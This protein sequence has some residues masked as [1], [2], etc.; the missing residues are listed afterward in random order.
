MPFRAS[1]IVT[2]FLTLAL[3][4]PLSIGWLPTPV[5]AQQ[6][7]TSETPVT[8]RWLVRLSAP[9]LAQ[10]PNLQPGRAMLAVDATSTSGPRFTSNQA[11]QYRQT[12]QQQQMALFASIQQVLPAAQLQRSYQTV[13]NGISVALPGADAQAIQRIDALPNVIGVYPDHQYEPH[14]YGSIPLINAETLWNNP[15]IGGVANAG[16]GMKIAVIDSGIMVDNPFLN[17]E[18]YAYP[19]GYPLGET[20]FTTPKVIAARIYVRPD[21]P[22]IPGE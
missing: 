19:E 15:S 5:A 11:L 13:F 6:G 22:P 2:W 1:L 8:G 21:A 4:I 12:L 9:P 18:G 7:I 16:A 3:L 20:D 10:V 17:P 14:L